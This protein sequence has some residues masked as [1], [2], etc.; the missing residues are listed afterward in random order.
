MRKSSD[1][2]FERFKIMHKHLYFSKKNN[3]NLLQHC[4]NQRLSHSDY[5]YLRRFNE[6]HSRLYPFLKERNESVGSYYDLYEMYRAWIANDK[7]FDDNFWDYYMTTDEQMV[8]D[9]ETEE[10]R[11]LLALNKEWNRQLQEAQKEEESQ[12]SDMTEQ[13]LDD[14]KFVRE[15]HNKIAADNYLLTKKM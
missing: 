2:A 15:Y 4:K 12:P 11:R 9:Y 1:D 8:K 10:K 5:V 3:L 6:F 13:D 14:E 7:R